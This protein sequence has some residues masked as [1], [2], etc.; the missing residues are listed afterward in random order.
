MI[1]LSAYSPCLSVLQSSELRGVLVK[2]HTGGKYLQKMGFAMGLF[3]NTN[4][5][6]FT[7]VIHP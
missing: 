1:Y 3:L 5:G 7:H 2:W 6:V 4:H